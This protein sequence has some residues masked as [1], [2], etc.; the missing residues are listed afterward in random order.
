MGSLVQWGRRR[1]CTI[2]LGGF[3]I[4][5]YALQLAVLGQ[6]GETTARWWLYSGQPP[7]AMSPGALLAPL[8]HD[9][10]TLTHLGANV[11]FLAIAGGF[12]EPRIG[13]KKILL[14]VFGL[15]YLSTYLTNA[16]EFLHQLWILAGI[17]GGVLAL[18][19]YSGLKLRHEVTGRPSEGLFWSRQIAGTLLASVLLISIPVFLVHQLLVVDQ[20]HSGH[21]VGLLLGCILYIIESHGSRTGALVTGYDS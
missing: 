18:W 10:S 12:A 16:T 13:S 2:Y 9:M 5:W 20:P 6:F 8:S 17:S 4:A 1:R 21:L 19:S 14:V 7:A 15:G 11:V 3:F